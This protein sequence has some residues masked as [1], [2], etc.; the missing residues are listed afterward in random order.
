MKRNKDKFKSPP[1][2]RGD[3]AA[4]PASSALVSKD[5]K[6]PK[7][8]NAFIK[9]EVERFVLEVCTKLVFVSLHGE[10]REVML[11]K[12]IVD[13]MELQC[14]VARYTKKSKLSYC[15]QDENGDLIPYL[16]FPGYDVI[17]VK[18]IGIR[19]DTY[20]MRHVSCVALWMWSTFR[21]VFFIAPLHFRVHLFSM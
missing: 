7:V 10:K 5:T 11:T 15:V 12:R 8:K 17:R 9:P 4:S 1:K 13:Y 18:E 2:Q 21:S 20:M 3:P 16:P 6:P 19:H 14:E